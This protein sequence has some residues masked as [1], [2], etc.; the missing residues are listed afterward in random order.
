MPLE[1]H[2]KTQCIP[3]KAGRQPTTDSARAAIARDGTMHR[4]QNIPF[5]IKPTAVTSL[6]AADKDVRRAA[7]ASGIS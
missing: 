1:R 7:I 2:V 6:V 5:W 4:E 3:C